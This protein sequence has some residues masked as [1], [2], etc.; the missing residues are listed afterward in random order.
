MT[1]AA[2]TIPALAA[3]VLLAACGK[4]SPDPTP[5]PTPDTP[6][7]P[8]PEVV[9]CYVVKVTDVTT[10]SAKTE[11]TPK[12]ATL[13]YYFGAVTKHIADSLKTDD[14]L[15]K[16][17]IKNIQETA[18]LYETPYAEFV[19]NYVKTGKTITYSKDFLSNTDYVAFAFT[20]TGDR[21]SGKDLVK[22]EFRTKEVAPVECSF[23]F[24]V[25]NITKNT[26]DIKVT[27]TNTECSYFWD[28]ISAA[29]YEKYGGDNGIIATHV[30]LIRR[31]VEIYQMAGYAKN[32][33]DF[34][35]TG[36]GGANAESLQG[37]REYVVFAFGLD[38]S[39]TSTT[40]VF[41]KTFSTVKPE[42][43]SLTF[44]TE[45]YDLKF[46]GAKIGF[47][48]SNDNETYFTDCM[49]YE[50]FSKFKSDQE[51]IDWVLDQAGSSITSYLSM[52]YHEVDASEILASNTKYVAYAF[53]YDGGATTG[54][55]TVEFTTPQ[56]PVGSEVTVKI[57]H[58]IVDA[59]T[60]NPEYVGQKALL[61]TLTPSPAAAHW[62]VGAFRED[63]SAYDDKVVIEALQSKGYKDKNEIALIVEDG[64]SYYIAAVAVEPSGTAGALAKLTVKV[65][66][67]TKASACHSLVFS[68]DKK[69]DP[70]PVLKT[71][72]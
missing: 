44:K 28:Y 68:A 62:F 38:P 7:D 35:T 12:E 30:D 8:E 16:Y 69:L 56:M 14:E 23:S 55:T 31:A 17:E 51:V 47:T 67:E 41:K 43:S 65:G 58:K 3:A 50:T 19:K 64:K 20:F 71:V 27:P 42:Q 6:T 22:A 34:L 37:G 18:D 36:A 15:I 5:N 4:T 40:K 29:D 61:L 59:G 53:G 39:G 9:P 1:G 33:N 54:L 57:D 66:S 63:I 21:L 46:N 70:I 24:E 11:V 25:G 52:G 26:A 49:D 10:W 48:P 13:N 2:R 32:F 45:V 60:I 72:R